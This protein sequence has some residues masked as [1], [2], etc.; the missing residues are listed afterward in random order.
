MAFFRR[1][2]SKK[3][4]SAVRKASGERIVRTA[5]GARRYGVPIGTPISHARK[6]QAAKSAAK[7]ATGGTP[8]SGGSK[9]WNRDGI[10]HNATINGHEL[11]V[12]DQ[13]RLGK[14]AVVKRNGKIIHQSKFSSVGEAKA[15]ARSVAENGK[16]RANKEVAGPKTASGRREYEVRNTGGSAYSVESRPGNDVAES[17]S[18]PDNNELRRLANQYGV[19]HSGSRSSS[20]AHATLDALRKKTKDPKELRRLDLIEDRVNRAAKSKSEAK[21]QNSQKAANAATG[22]SPRASLARRARQSATADPARA[23]AK[24]KAEGFDPYEDAPTTPAS[25]LKRGD[26]IA[27]RGGEY[28]VERVS[29]APALQG[30]EVTT[31]HLMDGSGKSKTIKVHSHTKVRLA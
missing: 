16:R 27:V 10:Y 22:A 14:M 8:K 28:K 12:E 24:T 4:R 21:A 29:K 23:R 31:L 18:V 19:D 2:L 20:D 5:E 13:G 11:F 9:G 6:S 25:S 3:H 17:L 26:M 1:K 7:R 15:Y 30:G